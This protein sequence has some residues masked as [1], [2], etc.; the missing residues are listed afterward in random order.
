MNISELRKKAL[1]LKSKDR[2]IYDIAF[3]IPQC[4]G[5]GTFKDDE[6]NFLNDAIAI[7]EE[8]ENLIEKRLK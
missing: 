3:N 7:Y 2:E 6:Y 1:E 5:T 4:E 8:I